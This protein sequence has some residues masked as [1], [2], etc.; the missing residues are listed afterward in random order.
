MSKRTKKLILY[1]VL[2]CTGFLLVWRMPANLLEY[3]KFFAGVMC[4][5]ASGVVSQ[6]RYRDWRKDKYGD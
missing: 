3:L 2:Y 4:I 6:D 1:I 5:Y